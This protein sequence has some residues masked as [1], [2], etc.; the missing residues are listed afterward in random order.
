[1]DSSA[2]CQVLAKDSGD[3]LWHHATIEGVEGGDLVHLRF[4]H[5]NK[6]IQTVPIEMVLPLT[7]NPDPD[8]DPVSAGDENEDPEDFENFVPEE[9]LDRIHGRYIHI[10]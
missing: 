8:E 1:M 10:L 7:E 5:N 2:G 4:S 6:D 9:L 3:H